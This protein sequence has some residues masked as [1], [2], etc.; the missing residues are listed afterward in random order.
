MDNQLPVK[1]ITYGTKRHGD[2]SYKT[3]SAMLYS[4]Q[5]SMKSSKV[6]TF[7]DS[8]FVSNIKR[9]TANKDLIIFED[10]RLRLSDI[11]I[12]ETVD[13]I[14]VDFIQSRM[15]GEPRNIVEAKTFNLILNKAHAVNKDVAVFMKDRE[16]YKG[17]STTHDYDSLRL[18][19]H[20]NRDF[21]IMYDA[22][23]RIVPL[24]GDGSLAE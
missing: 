17:K 1:D 16:I 2:R 19:T 18:V 20:D 4:V 21:L 9:V 8:S 11:K 3:A 13:R 12:I 10:R 22:V 23:K 6:V 7:D 24:E 15:M 5:K 14:D